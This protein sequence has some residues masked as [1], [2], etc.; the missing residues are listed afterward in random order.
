MKNPKPKKPNKVFVT[1][2]EGAHKLLNQ[3]VDRRVYGSTASEVARHLIIMKLD[4]FLEKGRL[5][6]NGPNPSDHS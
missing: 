1:L 6:E 5:Q 3:L 4:D 2:P